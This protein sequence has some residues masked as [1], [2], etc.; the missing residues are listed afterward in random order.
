MKNKI[1]SSV[2][3]ILCIF[4][5]FAFSGC[6]ENTSSSKPQ[7]AETTAVP[8]AENVTSAPSDNNSFDL[9]TLHTFDPESEDPFSGVWSITEGQGSQ[10]EGFAYLF[11][12]D[13][14]AILFTGNTGYHEK[15][16]LDTDENGEQTFTAQLMFGINGVYTYEFNSSNNEVV[17]TNTDSEQKTTMKKIENYSPVPSAP[18][19]P[20]TDKNILGAW[21]SEDGEYFYFDQSGIMY[22]NLYNTMFT[23]A[24]YSAK[25]G[26]IVAEY[27]TGV[28][29]T[30]DKYDYS[31]DGDTLTLNDF[32]YNRID[33]EELL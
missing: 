8:A 31:V 33:V 13:G 14:G 17:L 2:S 9:N 4:T 27:S 6:N 32:K 23:Y 15:Y 12:G 3:L 26:K 18:E 20:E 7:S 29:N 28:E 16:I 11:D 19:K 10:Y 21:K 1:I 24:V 22:Q 25:D 5:L 30:S